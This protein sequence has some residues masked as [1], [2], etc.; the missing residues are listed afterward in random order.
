MAKQKHGVPLLL[1]IFIPGL[2][3]LVKKKFIRAIFFF[4]FSGSLFYLSFN[5]GF[6]GFIGLIIYI[7][8]LIDAY[9]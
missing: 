3:Q 1:S 4:L 7:W 2:G 6:F 5:R 9:N 8:N